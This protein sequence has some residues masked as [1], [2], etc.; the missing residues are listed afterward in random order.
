MSEKTYDVR[1]VEHLLRA[2]SITPEEIDTHLESLP[3]EADEGEPTVTRFAGAAEV[4][5]EA[6]AEA[7]EPAKA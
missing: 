4:E 2:G 7:P 1:V 6:E 3:D 5:T